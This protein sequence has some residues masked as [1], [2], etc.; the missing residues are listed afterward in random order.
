MRK[1][2]KATWIT[3]CFIIAVVYF[4]SCL[5]PYIPPSKISLISI[6]ALLFPYLFVVSVFCCITMFFIKK[7]MAVI[8]L[9]LMF[10]AGLKNIGNTVSV[11][12]GNWAMPKKAGTL[13]II[14]WNVEKF[15]NLSPQSNPLSA[16]RMEMLKAIEKYNPDILCMQELE[17]VENAVKRIEVKRELD[18]L[19]F[20]YSFFS[21]DS[22]FIRQTNK[23]P[24]FIVKGVA[25]F[26]RLPLFNSTRVNIITRTGTENMVYADVGFGSRP[27]R[28]FTAHLLSFNAQTNNNENEEE[29]IYH[30]PYTNKK[31]FKST[32][33]QTEAEHEKE[34]AIIRNTIKKSPYPVVYCGDINATPASYTYNK[35]R[36]NMQDAF[37]EKGR[38]IGATYYGLLNT[39]RIDVCLVDNK[40]KVKQCAVPKLYLSDH[41]PVVTDITWK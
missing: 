27:L 31:I 41:F 11:N 24:V 22:V 8:A 9:L 25:I 6:L 12:T 5:T 32:I 40:L 10:L 38:G 21:N 13:R 34:V 33:G 7:S 26:S 3:I 16:K 20:I 19:G 36:G 30:V 29:G 39:L 4:V 14:T 35:L 28:I 17:N 1:V 37:L 2:L 18:S 23:G 15:V